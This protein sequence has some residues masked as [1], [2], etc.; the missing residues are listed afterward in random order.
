MKTGMMVLSPK[1]IESMT[2]RIDKALEECNVNS[3]EWSAPEKRMMCMIVKES[4]QID[5]PLISEKNAA[6]GMECVY[7]ISGLSNAEK[8]ELF[9]KHFPFLID[10]VERN[11]GRYDRYFDLHSGK[12]YSRAQ[13]GVIRYKGRNLLVSPDYLA[14]GGMAV[15]MIFE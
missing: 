5:Y 12:T 10:E 15:D 7:D 3:D 4:P 9:D 13:F 1:G 2:C 14:T 11:E 8:L 6:G